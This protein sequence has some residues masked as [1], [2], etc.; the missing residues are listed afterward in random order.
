M[1][2]NALREGPAPTQPF[3]AALHHL[4]GSADLKDW[5]LDSNC[6][7]KIFGFAAQ[8]F[9]KWQTVREVSRIAANV[10]VLNA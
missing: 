4:T 10:S 9:G 6:Q 2:T 7:L 3:K 8:E 5:M 1:T